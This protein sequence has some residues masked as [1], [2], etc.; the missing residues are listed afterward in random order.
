MGNQGGKYPYG[1]SLWKSIRIFWPSLS[2]QSTVKVQNGRKNSFWLDKWLGGMSL[3][4]RYPDIFTL[5]QHQQK[6]VAE[7][8]TQGW[9]LIFRR[10]LNDWEIPR[11]LELFKVLESFQGI[12]TGEDYLWW[13][14]HNKGSY[15]VKEGYKQKITGGIQDFKWPWKQIWRIKVPHKVPC[16]T[17]LLAKEAVLTFDNVAKRGISLCNRCSLCGKANETLRHLFLHCNFIEQSQRHI[18]VYA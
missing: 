13:Q 2:N 1:I 10:N 11:I 6:T 12:Q 8:W 15:K 7:M 5:A 4:D 17:W 14:G 18:L 3:K 16:F 9:D